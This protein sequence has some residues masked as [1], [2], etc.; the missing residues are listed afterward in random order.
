MHF[1]L[2]NTEQERLMAKKSSAE[3]IILHNKCIIPEWITTKN[4]FQTKFQFLPWEK[5]YTAGTVCLEWTQWRGVSTDNSAKEG[6]ER[7]KDWSLKKLLIVL[8]HDQ[9]NMKT[10]VETRVV[11][12][13]FDKAKASCINWSQ[14]L[15]KLDGR[16]ISRSFETKTWISSLIRKAN[17]NIKTGKQSR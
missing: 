9:H 14:H 4:T 13:H 10:P 1:K 2:G 5:L 15:A 8:M 11:H 7:N 6:E 12:I 16:N 17:K 3:S